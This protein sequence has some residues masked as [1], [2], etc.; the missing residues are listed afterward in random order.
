MLLGGDAGLRRGEAIALEWT[1]VDL[2]RRTM[3]VQRSSWNGHVTLPK[4]GRTRRL[5]LTERLAVALQAHRHLK[6][7]RVLYY[8]DGASPT[9]KEIRMWM[10]RAQRRAVLP[11]NGGY[12]ILRHTFCS[13][14]AMQGA[15]AKAI[16]ELAGH[17]DL[18][19]TQRYMHLS[20]AH[21][22]AA[23]RLLDRRPVDDEAVGDGLE[24]SLR[25]EP[26]SSHLK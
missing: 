23:I 16:Q 1:D 15:T 8:D 3:H 25:P 17:Q 2:R 21:K 11:A 5:P 10:E 14:L 4:G 6:G 12:H 18:T 20:P 19:T 22:D 26:E 9:N 24:T 7:P 13:H